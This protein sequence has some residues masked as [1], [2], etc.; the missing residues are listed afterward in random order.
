MAVLNLGLG[1]ESKGCSTTTN[2]S[3]KNESH[4]SRIHPR[5]YGIVR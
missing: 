3:K 2:N 1:A 5:L 4:L